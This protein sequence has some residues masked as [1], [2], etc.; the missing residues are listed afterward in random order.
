MLQ[1]LSGRA[2]T[3]Q[4]WCRAL[5]RAQGLLGHPRSRVTTAQSSMRGDG[6]AEV[7]PSPQCLAA[8]RSKRSSSITLTH[9]A[10]KSFTNFSL[11]SLLP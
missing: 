2:R 8:A 1:A 7:P 4:L 6:G 9:A 5:K 3:A 10:T 11:A